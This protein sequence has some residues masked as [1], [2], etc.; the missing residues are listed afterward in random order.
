MRPE[1]LP[2]PKDMPTVE[3]AHSLAE[4]FHLPMY[5]TKCFLT[6]TNELSLCRIKNQQ[7]QNF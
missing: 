2:Q 4:R 5:T 6:V 7:Y 1:S 3:N